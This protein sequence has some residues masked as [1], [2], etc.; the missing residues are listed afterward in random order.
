VII[1]YQLGLG[2]RAYSVAIPKRCDI[3]FSLPSTRR[4]NYTYYYENKSCGLLLQGYLQVEMGLLMI[5][6]GVEVI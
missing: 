4:P 3:P 5:S 1:G 6:K 2:L